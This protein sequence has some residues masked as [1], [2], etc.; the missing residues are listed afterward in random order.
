MGASATIASPLPANMSCSSL[1][2]AVTEYTTS[3]NNRNRRVSKETTYTREFIILTKS[4][5]AIP[6]PTENG[7]LLLFQVIH[8]QGVI[9]KCLS[10]KINNNVQ[11]VTASGH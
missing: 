4:E 1:G 8:C 3:S 2:R 6:Y 7:R 9:I 5:R 11:K 10:E